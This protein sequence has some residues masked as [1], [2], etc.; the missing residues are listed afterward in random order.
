[1]RRPNKDRRTPAKQDDSA[2][3]RYDTDDVRHAD[4][5]AVEP[6][7]ADPSACDGSDKAERE[8]DGPPQDATAVTS[9]GERGNRCNAE[10]GYG[11]D[12]MERRARQP[13][14]RRLDAHQ[15]RRQ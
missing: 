14:R 6:R 13:E 7:D 2:E 10:D 15:S 9:R 1:M 4:A 5:D 8:R 11:D 12:P 3:E